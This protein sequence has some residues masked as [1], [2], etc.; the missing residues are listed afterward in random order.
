MGGSYYDEFLHISSD[1]LSGGRNEIYQAEVSVVVKLESRVAGMAEASRLD[2]RSKGEARMVVTLTG[3]K[4]GRSSDKKN[5]SQ[6]PDTGR[7]ASRE[8]KKNAS[9]N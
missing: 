7:P 6:T 2:T 3:C 5:D 8:L 4:S 1:E 9:N